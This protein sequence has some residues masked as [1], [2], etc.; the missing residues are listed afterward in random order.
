MYFEWDERKRLSNIEKHG[1][2][3]VD[4]S[5]VFASHPNFSYASERYGEQ[6]EVI[7]GQV[8]KQ[9]IAVVFTRRQGAISIIS[10][11]KAR[12]H[13]RKHYEALQQ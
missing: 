5:R 4:A 9:V 10:A 2:D 13:E 3:F 12:K 7:I 1:I 11:R 6:R 8:H